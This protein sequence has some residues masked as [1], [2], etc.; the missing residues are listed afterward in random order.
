MRS[1]RKSRR[2]FTALEITI[3][4]T[5]MSVFLTALALFGSS[6]SGFM[7]SKTEQSD[8]ESRVRRIIIKMTQELMPTGLGALGPDP[9]PQLGDRLEYRKSIGV[10]NGVRVWG[11]SHRLEFRYEQGEVDDGLDN[12][13]NGL[14]DEGVVLWTRS[15]D[16]VEQGVVWCH[17]VRECLEGEE[18]NGVDDNGN[19]FV[20]ESGLSFEVLEDRIVVRLTVE[21]ASAEGMPYVQT[22]STSIQPRN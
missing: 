1:G 18:D 17:G 7:A 16:G 11:D 10:T 19:G 20:D 3:D 21:R 14:V 12:N 15:I 4:V 6:S 5:I 13:G 9:L 8:V 2:G 22:L